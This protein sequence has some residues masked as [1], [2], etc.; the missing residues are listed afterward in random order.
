[1]SLGGVSPETNKSGVLWS[2]LPSGYPSM[3]T[4]KSRDIPIISDN[5]SQP[6]DKESIE[7]TGLDT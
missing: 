1:M 2:R 3:S 7:R 5:Y 6:G 4:D